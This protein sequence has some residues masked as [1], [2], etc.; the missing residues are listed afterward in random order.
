MDEQ[1]QDPRWLDEE[2][3]GEEDGEG[4]DAPLSR[5]TAERSP[6]GASAAVPRESGASGNRYSVGE[7]LDYLRRFVQSGKTLVEFCR[8]ERLNTK[9]FCD[10]RRQFDA[11]GEAGLRP[12][13][14]LRNTGGHSGR[15]I[16]ADERRALVES[17]LRM[18]LS[19]AVFARTYGISVSS[20]SK[21]LRRYHAHGPKGLE[22]G[23]RGR[24]PGSGGGGARIALPIQAEIVNTKQRF[25]DF[26]MRK[27]RDYMKRFFGF[28]VSAGGVRATLER[29]GIAPLPMLKKR[30]RGPD[31][32]R[33]FERAT[34]MDLWQS[35]ITSYVLTRNSRRVY[36][37]VFLDDRS[38]Y[39]VAWSLATRQTSAFVC[40]TLLEGIASFGKP[41]EVLTDQ[42]RQYFAWRGKSEFQK[43][44]DKE[45]IRHV[46]ARSHHPQTVGK[47]ERL[48]KTVGTEFWERAQPQ[49]LDDARERLGHF[50]SHY[51]HFRPHQSLEG[52]TPA[53]R[54]FGAETELRAMLEAQQAEHELALA[55]DQPPRKPVFLIGQVGDQKVSMR[56]LDGRIEFGTEGGAIEAMAL[57]D[58][59]I[60]QTKPEA[61]PANPTT[62]N[63]ENEHATQ[64]GVEHGTEHDEPESAHEQHGGGAAIADEPAEPA[65]GGSD[66]A[67]VAGDL[68]AD[69]PRAQAPHASAAASGDLDP[70]PV[71]S[72]ESGGV[73]A[74]EGDR[75]LDHRDVDRQDEQGGGGTPAEDVAA[76]GVAAVAAGGVGRDC[77]AVDPAAHAAA[78][79][80]CAAC[81]RPRGA[82]EA[83]GA[84]ERSGALAEG[85]AAPEAGALGDRAGERAVAPIPGA[86]KV[87][88]SRCEEVAPSTGREPSGAGLAPSTA[89][90]SQP[91]CERERFDAKSDERSQRATA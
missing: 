61:K 1:E 38:R 3:D 58:A 34:P 16:P 69:A 4:Q 81:G 17:F 47:C 12:K 50:F 89:S 52:M 45:G 74:G 7:K 26:G 87:G 68:E 73:G 15:V 71:G 64:H 43:L 90:E 6:E 60:P 44:L 75:A 11:L 66:A 55:I 85:S 29:E 18:K 37:T 70:G 13:P 19:Q 72:G 51:N 48:W 56:A 25:P 84:V 63:P 27:V 36:L 22:P 82:G 2:R 31:R 77:G 35:D 28:K 67:G 86:E 23:K 46:V 10:W 53:D 32:I 39:V 80:V 9:S 5:G 20:L 59:G 40:D 42:G 49:D 24:K 33:R 8:R 54:F 83:A 65:A 88:E 41:K 21:W 14:N 91:N 57:K 76:P 62:T 30:R 79:E 78:A